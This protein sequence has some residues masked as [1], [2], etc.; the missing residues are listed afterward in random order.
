M[1][2]RKPKAKRREAR[3]TI[4]LTDEQRKLVQEVAAQKGLD[5]SEYIRMV[6]VES[7]K[8]KRK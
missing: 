8:S 1:E 2:R 6:V 3:V 4:R 5:E 7:I